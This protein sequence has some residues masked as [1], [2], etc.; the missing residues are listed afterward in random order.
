MN[1]SEAACAAHDA[2]ERA[3]EEGFANQVSMEVDDRDPDVEIPFG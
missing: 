1:H 3:L 2:L